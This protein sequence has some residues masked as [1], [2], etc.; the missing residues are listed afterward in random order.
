[1]K[2]GLESTLHKLLRFRRAVKAIYFMHRKQGIEA[3]WE[4]RNV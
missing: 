4:F 2:M 1:M 3:G